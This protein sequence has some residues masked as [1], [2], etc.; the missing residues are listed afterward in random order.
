MHACV[1][2]IFYSWHFV[3]FCFDGS[4]DTLVAE[5]GKSP[6]EKKNETENIIHNRQHTKCK[7]ASSAKKENPFFF[8]FDHSLSHL[9]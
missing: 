2:F 3:P 9:I 7:P 8:S 4:F 5:R 1:L 6:E